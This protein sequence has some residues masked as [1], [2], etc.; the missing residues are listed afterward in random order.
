MASNPNNGPSRGPQDPNAQQ[1]ELSLWAEPM[2]EGD[3]SNARPTISEAAG[4]IKTED[5][6]NIATYPCARTG[7]LQGIGAG[8]GMGGLR[9]V[10]GGRSTQ[11]VPKEFKLM[12]FAQRHNRISNELGCG[13]LHYGQHGLIRV[14]SVSKTTREEEDEEA[15]R[16]HQPRAKRAGAK[17]TGAEVGAE[18]SG[19]GVTSKEAVV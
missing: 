3:M 13:L 10:V 6:A 1:K 18:A 12:G 14:V 5:F 9:F 19:G 8:F 16:G 11:H 15:R 2:K 4:T 7:F 17:T